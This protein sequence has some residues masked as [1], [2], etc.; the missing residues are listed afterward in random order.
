ML[1]KEAL[2]RNSNILCVQETHFTR[3][4]PL[5]CQRRLYPIIFCQDEKK[6][7]DEDDENLFPF[8]GN[9]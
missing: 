3:D 8:N 2:K 9:M 6:G 4:K 5:K 7:S 1:W